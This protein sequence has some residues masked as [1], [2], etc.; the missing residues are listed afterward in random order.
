MRFGQIPIHSTGSNTLIQYWKL[1][2][3]V[4]VKSS[5]ANIA[6][7]ILFVSKAQ[8]ESGELRHWF[9]AP[10]GSSL[11]QLLNHRPECLGAI[12]WPYMCN[13]WDAQTRL[14]CIRE[15]HEAEDAMGQALAFP[16]GGGVR[17][18][19]LS[20]LYDTLSVVIDRP[21]WF[22]REGELT[23][24]LFLGDV[25]AFSLAFSFARKDGMLFAYVGAIQ[26]RNIA[27]IKDT[28]RDM[29]KALHG[30][31]PRDFLIEI[32]RV[33]CRHARVLFLLAVTDASRHHRSTYFG[34]PEKSFSLNYDE[35]WQDRGGVKENADFFRLAVETQVRAIED[36]PPNK[37]SMYRR[38]YAL[39]AEIDSTTQEAFAN[40]QQRHIPS[41]PQG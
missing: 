10:E 19:E 39:L 7:R 33:Y 41:L 35:V 2:K 37:R 13:S 24:N 27:D 29:T 4:H 32:F 11:R 31:R 3:L 15:H 16:F 17:L 25:R 20:H 6:R 5:P 23:I 40:M 12:V 21:I 1:S 9:N 36:I 28:Y 14:K 38:R 18:L 26:G 30:M 22:V 34:N 8:R